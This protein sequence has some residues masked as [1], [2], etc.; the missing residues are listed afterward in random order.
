MDELFDTEADALDPPVAREAPERERVE[1][2]GERPEADALEQ[3]A[4]VR[5][6]QDVRR[7]S[8]RDD[9]PAADAWEQAIEE[10]LD[11][12]RF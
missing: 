4:V 7:P 11:D 5:T 3:A 6:E 8:L 2:T 1:L 12:D 9:V 10:P